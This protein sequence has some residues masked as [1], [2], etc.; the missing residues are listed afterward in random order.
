MAVAESFVCS[1]ASTRCPVSAACSAMRGGLAVAHLADHDDVRVLPQ[2]VAERL[3]EVDADLGLDGDLVEGVDD[4]LD[5]VLDG[6]DVD[7]GR[8]H[9]PERRVERRGLAA[10]RSGR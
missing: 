3:G 10:A 9:G 1:V 5:R 4:D 6:D 7:L 8:R 2:D